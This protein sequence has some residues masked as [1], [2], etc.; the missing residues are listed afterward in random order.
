MATFR[1]LGIAAYGNSPVPFVQ[2]SYLVM[3]LD[4]R[5]TQP[6]Y[7]YIPQG[8][9]DYVRGQNLVRFDTDPHAVYFDSGQLIEEPE[10]EVQFLRIS[11]NDGAARTADIVFIVQPNEVVGRIYKL[12]GD[13]LPV[14]NTL[15]EWNDFLAAALPVATQIPDGPW[16]PGIPLNFGLADSLMSISEQDEI[17]KVDIGD[18]DI[19]TGIGDDIVRPYWGNDI[20]DLG[21]NPGDFDI[22]AYDRDINVLD[23]GGNAGIGGITALMVNGTLQITDPYGDTDFVTGAEL[24]IGTSGT[25]GAS[26]TDTIVQDGSVD[27]F[28]FRGNAGYTFYTGHANTHDVLDYSLVTFLGGGAINADFR[29]PGNEAIVNGLNGVDIVTSVDEVIGSADADGF[30]D[31]AGDVIW[32]GG[33]GDDQMFAGDGGN[34]EFHGDGGD[35]D[36]LNY[37]FLTGGQGIEVS[38]ARGLI[39]GGA[40]RDVYSGVEVLIGTDFRD[41]FGGS[42]GDDFFDAGAGDDVI[43][44]RGGNDYLFGGDGNDLIIGLGGSEEVFGDAGEDILRLYGGNDFAFGGDDNDVLRLGSGD[45]VGFGDSGNDRLFGQGDNDELWGG[46]GDDYLEGGN[47]RDML[48][49]EQGNDVLRGDASLD[50]LFGGAGDDTYYGG[51][52]RDTFIF[53]DGLNVYGEGS[54]GLDRIKDWEDGLDMLDLTDFG[55]T[56]FDTQ[57]KV[58]ATNVG[59]FNMRIDFSADNRVVIENFRVEDFDASDVILVA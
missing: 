3:T 16:M 45:D 17:G 52:G 29:S 5:F 59:D 18:Q 41:V 11:W 57:V 58:L 31:G 13:D 20:V 7:Q 43:R 14:I 4:E 38:V 9:P 10:I 56:D 42:A 53:T 39:K 33:E 12:T 47:G 21:E 35:Y 44:S 48:Y 8:D 28:M 27:R 2:P 50:T 22:L 1:F 24:L 36:M 49:G 51:D 55:F 37:G 25:E 40:G 6:S 34:D 30:F 46:A 15:T 23:D 54:S 32:R 26:T 19:Q